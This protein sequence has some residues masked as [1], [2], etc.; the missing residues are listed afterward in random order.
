MDFITFLSEEQKKPKKPK[1]RPKKNLW[2]T[3]K[4][5]W[6]SDLRF[7]R[8]D[9]KLLRGEGLVV[10]TNQD[11]NIVYGVWYDDQ[12]K[13]ITVFKPRPIHVA[14]PHKARMKEIKVEEL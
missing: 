8:G 13:G 11:E 3:E 7:E 12:S 1:A 14:V 4:M 10:A 2:F 6:L 9:F 5:W